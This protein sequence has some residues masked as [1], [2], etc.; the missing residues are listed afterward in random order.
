MK[1]L[2]RSK[3]WWKIINGKEKKPE[4]PNKL[5]NFNPSTLA[6]LLK[7]TNTTSVKK[8]KD[9]SKFIKSLT[10]WY[11]KNAKVIALFICNINPNFLDKIHVDNTAKAIWDH[12]QNQFGKRGFTLQHILFIHLMIS[13][14]S[15]F[16]TL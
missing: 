2:L 8:S 10:N 7:E 3:D 4:L 1:L 9:N 5:S 14:L 16:N 13:K 6:S 11:K 15:A 12:L